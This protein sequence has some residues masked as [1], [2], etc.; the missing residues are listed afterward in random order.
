[1]K[2]LKAMT[3]L[4][5]SYLQNFLNLKTMAIIFTSIYKPYFYHIL[6]FSLLFLLSSPSKC[7]TDHVCAMYSTCYKSNSID[8]FSL[9]VTSLKQD[10]SGNTVPVLDEVGWKLLF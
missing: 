10:K 3:D 9:E 5:E 4:S 7:Y 6:W 8:N 1:M 2:F